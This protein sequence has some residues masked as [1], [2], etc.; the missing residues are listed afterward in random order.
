M[1]CKQITRIYI[2]LYIQYFPNIYRRGMEQIILTIIHIQKNK[3]IIIPMKIIYTHPFTNM[4]K[5]NTI[6]HHYYVYI[7]SVSVRWIIF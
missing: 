7:Y 6:Y 1:L 4:K 2:I 3:I 5:Y